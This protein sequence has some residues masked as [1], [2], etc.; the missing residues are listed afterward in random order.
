[1]LDTLPCGA[2]TTASDALWM[3]VPMLTCLGRSFAGRVAASLLTAMRCPE[4]IT[5]NLDEYEALALALA[6][7]GE[8]LAALK[9]KIALS[10]LTAP[11]FDAPRFCRHI[12]RAYMTM[13]DLARAGVPPRSFDVPVID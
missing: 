10:R 11:L 3:G 2:H 1:M 6:R 12:E 8:K 5:Y 4:L 9:A 7:D 13:M